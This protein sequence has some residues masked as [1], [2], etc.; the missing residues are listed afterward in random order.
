MPGFWVSLL[1]EAWMA[2]KGGGSFRALLAPQ[3]GVTAVCFG[4]CSEGIN[5]S[6]CFRA[7]QSQGVDMWSNV[8]TKFF[9]V[10]RAGVCFIR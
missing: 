5:A 3:R 2:G 10:R 1:H 9:I 4:E 7:L 8:T 6:D